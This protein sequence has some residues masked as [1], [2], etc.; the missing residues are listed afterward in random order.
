ML[1]KCDLNKLKQQKLYLAKEIIEGTNK[2]KFKV[3]NIE[4][5]TGK[6][7]TADVV[8]ATYDQKNKLQDKVLYV[9]QRNADAIAEA[10][11][12]NSLA[13]KNIAYAINSDTYNQKEFNKVKHIIKTYSIV[14]ISHEK[15]KV[16]CSDNM[17]RRFFIAGR[18]TLVIDEFLNMANSNVLSVSKESLNEF[19]NV[20][21]DRAIKNLY[22]EAIQ[23]LLDFV[24][25]N[26]NN[27]HKNTFYNFKGDQ[28]SKIKQF[29]NVIATVKEN[30]SKEYCKSINR[31]KTSICEEL[32]RIKQFF[33]QTC[34]VEHDIIY[35]VDRR[36]EHFKLDNNI[37]LDA[38]A[39]INKAYQI[40]DDFVVAKQSKVLDHA[41][42]NFK[43][44][45]A[46]ST[47]SAKEKALDYYEKIDMFVEG[48]SKDN[49]LVISNKE[50][51]N[52]IKAKNIN[53]FGNVTGSNE[54][55]NLN[56]VIIA[57]TPNVPY[58][59]YVLEYIYY[60]KKTFQSNESWQGNNESKGAEKVYRF[61]NSEFEDY[62]VNKNVEIMYQAIKRVN[63]DMSRKTKALVICNDV[64]CLEKLAKMFKNANIKYVENIFTYAK[65]NRTK[66]SK[67]TAR[68]NEKRE[69]SY[70]VKFIKICSEIMKNRR[71]DLQ[72][73]V[74]NRKKELV[75]VEGVYSKK[76]IKDELGV[77]SNFFAD[78]ILK[79]SDV[80]DYLQRHNII[81]AGQSLDF[82][83]SK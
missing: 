56:N 55:M 18:R 4:A 39:N 24:I 67:E 65:K 52:I 29:N 22:I 81:N 11:R 48:M 40:S 36:C 80:I 34:V 28:K 27:K 54:Y 68:D 21:K 44:L 31:T 62:R 20:L 51:E 5:G 8:F 3:I 17:Q 14:I 43:F 64:K 33:I 45:V 2:E 25:K 30:L 6:S 66:T 46:N 58:R 19:E 37:I 79:D 73:Q 7:M 57:H 32:Q 23:E 71:K 63:R 12:I 9:K 49:T 13:G 50:D 83:G 69:N 60:S 38:T 1:H 59:Q 82:Q 77:A 10:K 15:Y 42:W 72:K 61:K 70:A 35:C 76:K 41:D 74:K 47:K 16:L 53:H 78:K 75:D 26:Q